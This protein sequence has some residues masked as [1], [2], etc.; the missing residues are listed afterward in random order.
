MAKELSFEQRSRALQNNNKNKIRCHQKRIVILDDCPRITNYLRPI[1]EPDLQFDVVTFNDEFEAV[2][3]ISQNEV[4]LV[5]LDINLG[6]S[7]GMSIRRVIK[8]LNDSDIQFIFISQ[9]KNYRAL[10]EG[11]GTDFPMFIQ[12]PIASSILK[13]TVYNCLYKDSYLNLV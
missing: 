11:I 8:S 5:I 9:D 13:K 6:E 1:L 3:Y 7:N 4:D 10:I 12:K 2:K